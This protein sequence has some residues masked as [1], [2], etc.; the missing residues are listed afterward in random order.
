M[1]SLS[2]AELADKLQIGCQKLHRNL[3][4]E[5]KRTYKYK[6]KGLQK[7][8]RRHEGWHLSHQLLHR[9]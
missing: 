3:V 8:N 1:T 2:G 5:F 9:R 6:D 4:E 7:D